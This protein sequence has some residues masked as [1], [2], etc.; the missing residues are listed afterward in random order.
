MKAVKIPILPYRILKHLMPFSIGEGCTG[1]IEEE[2]KERLR[3]EGNQKANRWIWSHAIKA[4]PK[5][6]HAHLFWGGGMFKNFIKIAFRNMKRHKGHAT[7]NI[8]GL[9]VG[10]SCYLLIMLYVGHEMSYD[11][12]HQ[13]S[14]RLFRIQKRYSQGRTSVITFGPLATTLADEYPE[15]VQAVRIE[16][17]DEYELALK[18]GNRNFFERG[19]Y[20]D[21]NFF[22]MFSYKVIQGDLKTALVEPFSIVITRRLAEKYFGDEDP[23]GKMLSVIEDEPYDARITALIENVPG[24]SHLHFDFLLSMNS[25]K[26]VYE[27][28]DFGKLW[29]GYDFIT[30]IELKEGINPAGLAAKFPAFIEKHQIRQGSEY[31]LMPVTEIHMQSKDNFEILKETDLQDVQ[32]LSAVA[33][34]I[35]IIACINYINLTTA[36]ALKRLK[37]IGVRKVVG[38][39]RRQLINQFL[40]ESLC[41]SL[42]A[43]VLAMLLSR[44]VHSVL[45]TLLNREIHFAIFTSSRLLPEL[46]GL[47]IIVG[48]LSG[49]YPALFI[50]RFQPVEALAGKSTFL[51][52]RSKI[53][54][55]FV[56]FQFCV[57]LGLIAGT[58][59]VVRQLNYIQT[60]D[61]GYNRE[62]ILAMQIRDDEIRDNLESVRTELLENPAVRA[63][64]ASS[65]VPNRITWGGSLMSKDN[66]VVRV[67]SCAVDFD[68][69]KLFDIDII[70]GRNFSRDFPSD[71]GGAFLLSE[72]AVQSVG[73]ESPLGREFTHWGYKT[74]RVVG[75]FKDFHFRSLHESVRPLYLLLD[76]GRV[77]VLFVKMRP[78]NI[79]STV[80]FVEK[81]IASFHPSHPFQYFFLD[82]SFNNMHQSERQFGNII[83]IFSS[84]AIF[85]ASLGLLGLIA[86]SAEMRTKEIGIRKVVGASALHVVTRMTAAYVAL[87]FFSALIAFPIAYFLSNQWLKGFVYK[88]PLGWDAFGLSGLIVI[89]VAYLTVGYHS[90][91]AARA[92][93][94]DAL[95]YE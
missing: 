60:K 55:I 39:F 44:A 83:I 21:A 92:N 71:R 16:H 63:V 27:E 68:Y 47:V 22:D 54:N 9:T 46:I 35:M 5:A 82:D 11:D 86:F 61:L 13:K 69:I 23:L 36:R 19:F 94:V 15:V 37:E 42:V 38:A 14:D 34:L 33:Y 59:I 80:N 2:F 49:I 79:P 77:R 95:R 62:H 12:F 84:L 58:I 6:F 32:F 18:Y 81:T 41:M 74:G 25:L 28:D 70:A 91:K 76:P 89:V 7:I 31:F 73:W 3:T 66:E 4:I 75:V 17:R 26:A 20:V 1:D 50:T 56:A 40:T 72:R 30:Y 93:P 88:V 65:H 53:R 64:S 10:M 51:S 85:I 52:R 87:I 48:L 45:N 8:L 43:F 90:I 24:N 57:S 29:S 67:N 78:D